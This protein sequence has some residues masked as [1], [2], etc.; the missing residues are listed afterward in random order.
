M[1]EHKLEVKKSKKRWPRRLLT[2]F[3][4]AMFIGGGYLLFL[5]Q[6]PKLTFLKPAPKVDQTIEENK[7]IVPG[8][9]IEVG[10]FEGGVET[11]DKGAWHRFPER[12]D[13]V[14]GGNFIISAHRFGLGATPQAT[15]ANSAF[16][17]ID[18][19]TTGD[20]IIVH[21]EGKEYTYEVA[22]K[23]QV[24]PTATEVEDPRDDHV[25]TMYSCTL[26]GR[27]DGRIIVEATPKFIVTKR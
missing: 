10:I 9:K 12:G 14:E 2:V 3:A 17:N 6:S 16:Y 5:T 22:K 19:M 8:A 4:I 7:V 23:Y 21:W 25:L 1:D 26:A 24:E 13:P 27:Y 20:E 18:D 15:Q 11:L